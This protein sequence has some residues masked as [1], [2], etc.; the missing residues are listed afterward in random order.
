MQSIISMTVSHMVTCNYRIRKYNN[1]INCTKYSTLSFSWDF[2]LL[3]YSYIASTIV[4]LRTRMR[5]AHA[6]HPKMNFFYYL[7]KVN[8]EYRTT[9]TQS[10]CK[11]QHN[12]I[13]KDCLNRIFLFI[14]CSQL[15]SQIIRF[16]IYFIRLQVWAKF[17]TRILSLY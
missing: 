6:N 17:G 12:L 16:F 11:Q 15:L 9:C 4:Y 1:I 13:H 3:I 14:I 7:K 2:I 5:C 10:L 8:E